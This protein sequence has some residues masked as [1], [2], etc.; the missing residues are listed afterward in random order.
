[1]FTGDT[2]RRKQPSTQACS[3]VREPAA[4]GQTREV[5]PRHGPPNQPKTAYGGAAG[6][7]LSGNTPV[8]TRFCE[9]EHYNFDPRPAHREGGTPPRHHGHSLF[10]HHM[11]SLWT[12][13]WKNGHTMLGRQIKD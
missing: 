9:H 7:S 3:K 1:M 2:G 11:H 5:L 13:M 6:L 10:P 4:H 12:T 8:N